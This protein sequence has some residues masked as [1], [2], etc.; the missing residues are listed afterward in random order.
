MSNYR[1]NIRFTGD[2]LDTIYACRQRVIIVKHT[3]EQQHKVAWVSFNPF[4]INTVDWETRFS[5]YASTSEVQ[6]GAK[7]SKLSTHDGQTQL[8]TIFDR[9]YFSATEPDDSINSSSYKV[10][11]R[12]SDEKML[13]FGLAQSVSVNGTAYMDNPVN[14]ILVPRG[15]S[16]VMTPIERIDVFLEANIDSSTV[17]TRIDSRSL[18]LTYGEGAKEFSLS[19]DS[20]NGVFFQASK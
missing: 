6:G 9:G 2:D 7:I 4:E 20:V 10:T 13:T 5:L 17:L 11:N 8:N 18:A 1:L 19:Y 3:A 12:N 16:A 14:A 15:Q